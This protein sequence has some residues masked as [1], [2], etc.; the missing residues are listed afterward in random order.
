MEVLLIIRWLVGYDGE[1]QPI[2]R[3]QN[4]RCAKEVTDTEALQIAQILEKYIKYDLAEVFVQTT[5]K[6]GE[7]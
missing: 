2:F 3:R 6:V 7:M 1:N 5:R 4:I